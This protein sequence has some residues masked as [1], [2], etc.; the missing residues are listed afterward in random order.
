M[1]DEKTVDFLDFLKKKNH[2]RRCL[3]LKNIQRRFKGFIIL[4]D[5]LVAFIVFYSDFKLEKL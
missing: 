3:E 1:P 5:Y 2:S 4:V